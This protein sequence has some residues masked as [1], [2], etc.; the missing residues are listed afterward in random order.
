MRARTEAEM[1][2]SAINVSWVVDGFGVGV[3]V[4]GGGGTG[5]ELGGDG[6]GVNEEDEEEEGD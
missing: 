4:L 1:L 6:G 2:L 3:G 5:G